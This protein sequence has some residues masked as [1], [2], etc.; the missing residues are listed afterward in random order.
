[1]KLFISILIFLITKIA[2]AH[3]PVIIGHDKWMEVPPEGN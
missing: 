3:G 2:I 1:M